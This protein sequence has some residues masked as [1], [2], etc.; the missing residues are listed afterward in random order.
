V[1][2]PRYATLCRSESG[3]ESDDTPQFLPPPADVPSFF[4]DPEFKHRNPLHDAN[5]VRDYGKKEF[6]FVGSRK[7]KV[8]FTCKRCD[9]RT[10]KMV[11]RVSI[12]Q[13]VVI[14]QCDG[15]KVR[16]LL[17]DNLGW[18]TSDKLPRSI[19]EMAALSGE[20]VNRVPEDVF[21]LEE[22]FYFD[23][24]AGSDQIPPSV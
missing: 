2:L 22:M 15:C 19:D 7:T 1:S 11:N 17:V 8:M 20:S 6:G 14:I 4:P 16:H 13:G 18:Y 21:A 10:M 3:E 23:S 5:E 24:A 9:T 12:E